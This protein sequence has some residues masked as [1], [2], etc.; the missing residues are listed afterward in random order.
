MRFPTAKTW[1]V[2]GKN[3]EALGT[4]YLKWS[5]DTVLD[6]DT[7]EEVESVL[8]RF[9]FARAEILEN[10]HNNHARH[11]GNHHDTHNKK[12]TK[13][14]WKKYIKKSK[15]K[16]IIIKKIKSWTAKKAKEGVLE[17][18]GRDIYDHNF[19][20]GI[21]ILYRI[22]WKN[23]RKSREEI[24]DCHN[25]HIPHDV[26]DLY[27]EVVSDLGGLGGGFYQVLWFPPPLTTE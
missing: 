22:R 19:V 9:M 8:L 23:Q 10:K 27:L 4:L 2:L 5:T 13:K 20:I 24:T 21:M 14:K 26:M 25:L 11:H 16:K 7:S 18:I 15:Q 3:K 12:T 17:P 6:G 1:H